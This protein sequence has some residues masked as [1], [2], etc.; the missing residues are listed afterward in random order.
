MTVGFTP[1]I[2]DAGRT[3]AAG[4]VRE[5]LQLATAKGAERL[6]LLE[7][8]GIEAGALR[9][10]ENRI[11]LASF[12]SLMRSA[13]ELCGEP[14][15]AL[16]FG[17]VVDCTEYS[18][19]SMMTRACATVADA[20]EQ[21]N[22]YERLVAEVEW[23]GPD[24]F[25]LEPFG[26]QV[27]LIDTR[28]EPNEL[29]EFTESI[30]AR[31]ATDLHRQGGSAF[32][33]AVRF[34]HE[35]R[36]DRSEYDRIFQVPVTFG[37]DRNALLMDGSWPH[38]QIATLPTYAF[39]ILSAHADALMKRLENSKTTRGQVESL[40]MPTL[41]TG[42][43][44]VGE[45]ARRLGVS[46]QTLFRRL[47]AEGVTFERVLDELRHTLALHYLGGKQVSVSETAYLLGFSE[48]AAFSRA[49][50]RWTGTTPGAARASKR[51]E[52]A[53]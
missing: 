10:N 16:H 42:E 38:Q 15:L 51:R 43:A 23:E 31:I 27:W 35:A 41:H 13:Q 8:S 26:G 45:I 20:L 2:V 48:A 4:M 44:N 12:V 37:S 39:G 52:A 53:G 47:R 25:R 49:F 17:E 32:L 1:P 40:L 11:P 28:T 33:H 18:V 14:A 5:W 19:V 29:P 9:D 7:R 22:R 3:C 30:F 46:R 6:T 21:R 50:K 24:R 34:T 36:A